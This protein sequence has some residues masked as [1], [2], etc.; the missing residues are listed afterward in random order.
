MEPQDAANVILTLPKYVGNS[1]DAEH[2]LIREPAGCPRCRFGVYFLLKSME[3]GP[4][5]RSSAPECP[6][7]DSG[8]RII[9]RQRCRYTH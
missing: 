5:F 9:T 8:Y 7:E 3:T 1:E 4:G 2:P 6:T